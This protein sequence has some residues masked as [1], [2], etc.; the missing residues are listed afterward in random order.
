MTKATYFHTKEQRTATFTSNQLIWIMPAFKNQRI[1]S[2]KMPHN[3]MHYLTKCDSLV[4]CDISKIS[5]QQVV[6]WG[7]CEKIQ[8]NI[9]QNIIIKRKCIC[10]YIQ[11][12]MT[13]F[14]CYLQQNYVNFILYRRVKI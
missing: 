10:G 12:A 7:V 13:S 4:T 9:Q 5:L 6:L 8:I 1:G 3:L 14:I 11:E 2:F